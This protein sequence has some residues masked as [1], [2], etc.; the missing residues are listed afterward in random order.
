MSP[1]QLT[2]LLGV[3]AVTTGAL[4]AAP[5]PSAAAEPCPDVEVVFA[6]GTFEPPGLGGIGQ[7][8]VDAVRVAGGGQVGIG[9]SGQLPRQYRL[10]YRCRGHQGCGQ[11]HRGDGG[12]LS[13]HEDRARRILPGRGRRRLRHVGGRTERRRTRRTCPIRCR[14]TIAN[15]V[16]AVVLF[17]SRRRKFMELIGTPPVE[18]GDLYRGQDDRPVRRQRPDLRRQRRRREP[19]SLQ[20]ERNDRPGSGFRGQQAL[21]ELHRCKSRGMP[22]PFRIATRSRIDTY[23]Y[24][25]GPNSP[26]DHYRHI[27]QRGTSMRR[28]AP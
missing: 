1:R 2:R 12:R 18:I 17:G 14:P 3:A 26:T 10:P 4:L 11:S 28:P 7:S 5:I 13:R 25:T 8:F 19:Q 21:A 16:A 24:I 27:S 15:H 23:Q 22:R 20:Q 9:L 6:R